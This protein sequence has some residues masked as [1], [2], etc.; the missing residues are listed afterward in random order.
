MAK[1]GDKPTY[2]DLYKLVEESEQ[3]LGS[4]IDDLA[5]VFYDFER[6]RLTT[7]E[8]DIIYLKTQLEEK[9]NQ[10]RMIVG[11]IAFMISSA[12]TILSLVFRK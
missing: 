9:K 8:K 10:E 2:Q 5:K 3:R 7:A 1:N 4:K 12:I 11:I 6:G